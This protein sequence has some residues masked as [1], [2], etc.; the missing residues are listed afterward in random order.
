MPVTQRKS[1]TTTEYDVS[2]VPHM[3]SYLGPAAEMAPYG[4]IVETVDGTVH[5]ITVYG[6]IIGKRG[7]VTTKVASV[8]FTLADLTGTGH[9]WADP[10]YE[11]VVIPGWVAELY[12]TTRDA[13][14][15]GIPA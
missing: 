14:P 9:N 13:L 15:Q 2:D 11:P 5:E 4:A 10:D 1:A 8:A 7:Q 6:W 12:A 3:D